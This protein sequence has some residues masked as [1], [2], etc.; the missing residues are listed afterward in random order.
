[1]LSIN[2]SQNKTRFFY[3]F[4]L[5]SLFLT[6]LFLTALLSLILSCTPQQTPEA[7]PAA[8][9]EDV[10]DTLHGVAVHD[11]YRWLENWENSEVKAWSAG[12]NTYARS[13]LAKLPGIQAIHERLSE[14]MAA[15]PESYSKLTWQGGKLFA[16]KKHPPLNQSLLVYMPSANDPASESPPSTAS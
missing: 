11:P 7:P 6:S 15:T 13:M 2:S 4:I 9:I 14:I 1:M 16:M 8:K 3:S 12:Q 5:K 10:V